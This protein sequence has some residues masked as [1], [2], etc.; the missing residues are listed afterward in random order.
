MLGHLKT[1]DSSALFPLREIPVFNVREPGYHRLTVAMGDWPVISDPE[2]NLEA[3]PCDLSLV[4]H[5]ITHELDLPLGEIRVRNG[6]IEAVRDSPGPAEA[7]R[8]R[9]DV[10]EALLLP[11][12]VDVHVHSR[13]HLGEGMSAATR[14]AAAGGVTTL[15]EMPFDAGAPVWNAERVQAKKEMAGQ[16]SLVDV[17]LCATIRPGGGL[18]EA[19]AMLDAG[20][21]CFKLST[22]QTDPDRFPRT[23]DHELLEAFSLMAEHGVR[24][25]MHAENDE[26][27]HALLSQLASQGR[28]PRAHAESHPPISET[29]AVAGLLELARETRAPLHLCHL[30]LGHSFELVARYREAGVPVTGETCPHYLVFE[31]ADL[32]RLGARVKTNPPPRLAVEREQ[33]WRSVELG[34][35][36][37]VS[38]DHAPWPLELKEQPN[39]FENAS[40]A[41]GVETL[42]SVT[43]SEGLRRGVS[44]GR[45]SWLLSTAPAA[46]FGLDHLKGDLRPGLDADI[47]AVKRSAYA[48]DERQLHSTAGWSPYQGRDLEA[49]VVL[50]VSRGD[51]VWD[52]QCFLGEGGRGEVLR[53]RRLQW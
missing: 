2:S 35:I 34:L 8:R 17:V 27:V 47:I 24:V 5:V 31:E 18:R 53:P 37:M 26:I 6:V 43:L 3:A 51:V 20:A 13:S 15:V 16:E 41:P 36:D 48:L 22:F 4:G 44:P 23:P 1:A 19:P 7:C 9:I 45:L 29:M 50:T 42:V 25:C 49:R 46:A 28:R 12:A 52:G 39:I 14:S 40:G 11:G 30:S 21:G 33:L 32:D 10:G 38:S